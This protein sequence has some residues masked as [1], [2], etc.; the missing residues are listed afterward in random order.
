MHFLSFYENV[1]SIIQVCKMQSYLKN[2]QFYQSYV[3]MKMKMKQIN[4]YVITMIHVIINLKKQ[5]KNILMNI[6]GMIYIIL[7]IIELLNQIKK[8]RIFIINYFKKY[9]NTNC[10]VIL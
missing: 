4:M 1:L 5:M 9:V 10:L 3:Q 2:N 7:F 8:T 6:L